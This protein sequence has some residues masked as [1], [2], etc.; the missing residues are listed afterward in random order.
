MIKSSKKFKVFLGTLFLAVLALF[1]VAYAA[2]DDGKITLTKTAKRYDDYGRKSHVAL[3]VSANSYTKS[4]KLDVVLVLD[5]SGSMA[6]GP[7]GEKDKVNVNNP[8]RLTSAKKAAKTFISTLITDDDSVK[9]G[10]VEYGESIK[11]TQALTENEKI[12]NNFIDNKYSARGGTNLQAG[13]EKAH[14]LLDNGSREDSKK[15]VVILTDGIPTFFNYEGK[16]YGH[17]DTDDSVCLRRGFFGCDL[18]KKPSEAAKEELD[19]LKNNYK[20]SDVYTI[21]LGNEKEAANILSKVNPEQENPLYKNYKALTGDELQ[22]RFNEILNNEI[23]TIGSSSVVTDTIPAKFKLTKESESNL[24][25]KGVEIVENEDGTTTL[26]WNIGTIETGKNYSLSYDVEALD[27]YHGSMY[28]N[29]S[30]I[31]KTTVKE[32]NPYYAGKTNQELEFNKPTTQVP[33]ITHDDN[34]SGYED[35]VVKGSIFDNDL[36]KIKELDK[37]KQTDKLEVRDTLIVKEDANTVKNN[38]GTYTLYKDGVAQGTLTIDENGKFT[39]TP[40]EGIVGDVSF[41]YSITTDVITNGKKDSVYSNES[42]VVINI[43]PIE[44]VE[45]EGS[46][47]WVDNNNQ[48]GIR[49][50]KI[51]VKLLANGNLVDSK[52]VNSKDNWTYKFTNLPKY[53]KYHENEE[54]YLIKYTIDEIEV[55]GYT[56]KVE[57]YNIV[58][59]HEVDKTKV[60]GTKTWVDNNNQDGIRPDKIRVNLLKNNKVIDTKEVTAND[61]WSYEFSNLDKNENGSEIKYSV[62]EDTITGYKTKIEGYNITNTHSPELYGSDGKYTVTKIW[63]DNNNQDGIRDSYEV[64]LTGVIEDQD[65]PVYENTV[66]LTKDKTSYTWTNLAKYNNGKEIKYTVD[67]TKVP[68]GYTK[69]VDG[70]KITNTHTPELINNNTGELKVTKIW[71]DNNNQDGIRPDKIKVSLYIDGKK[72]DKSLILSLDNNW[73]GK[74]TNLP[75]YKSE[76]KEVK[77]TVKEESIKNYTS[78][79]TG[80][81]ENGYVITNT[82][83][84]EL[85]GSDGKYTVTKIWNDNNNQDGIR[86]SYEV[87]LTG[88]I[89][90]QDEPVYE[91]T[92]TLTK[93]KTNYT[94][95]NL[96]KYN[97]GKEI[98]YTVDETKVPTGYTKIVDGTKITNIHTPELINN[99]TGELKVTKIW[100]DNNNQDGIRPDKIKVSLYIDGKKS[101]K[102][103]IL[104]LDNNWTG[105]FTNLPKY[106]SEGKEVKYTVKEESIK[107]YTSN[108][109]GSVENGYVITNTHSPELYGS[110]G[111]YTVTKI[112]NDNN[113]QDGIRDSYEVTLTGVIE[114]QDE[115][116]Y[117]NTVTLTKDKTSY[118]WSNL[119][120]YNNGKE[121]KYTVD[122]TKVPTGYTKLV[123]GTKITNTHET[124][125]TEVVGTKTWVDNNNQDGV[126]PKEIIVKLLANGVDTGKTVKVT[127][128]SNWQYS[129]TN[130]DTNSDGKEIKYTVEEQ[131]VPNYTTKV[132]GYNIINTHEVEKTEVAGTKTWLDNDNQDGKR[133]DKITIR[134]LANNVDTG[135]KA[136][137]SAD[138]DW[139]YSFTNL[140]KKANGKDIVYTVTED[141]VESYQGVIDGYNI[142]NTHTP[143]TITFSFEKIWV[144]AN[145]Q[146][147][148]RPDKIKVNLLAD[149]KV[150]DT[151]EITGE[152]KQN[153]QSNFTD[154]PKYNNGREI[155]YSVKEEAVPS[156][157]E[158]SYK[159]NNTII[160]THSPSKRMIEGTKTWN[161]NDNNDGIR[162]DKITVKLF[163]N[164]IDT[165]KT[166]EVSSK[167]NWQYKFEDLPEY[168]DGNKIIYTVNEEDVLGYSSE[169]KGFDI[170]NTH[171]VEKIS[172]SGTKIWDDHNNNDGIRPDEITVKLLANGIDTGKKVEVSS[173]T[174]W[175]YSFTDLNKYKNG[176]EITYSLEEVSVDG[177]ISEVNQED[178][179]ITNTHSPETITYTVNKKWV[180]ANNN[181]GIRPESINVSILANG[182]V[183]DKTSLSK[184]NNWTYTFGPYNKYENGNLIQ[185]TIV[186]DA[187]ECYVQTIEEGVIDNNNN[188]TSV[189]T[190]THEVEKE[191]ITI[192]KIWNDNN[193]EQQTRP[194]FINVKLLANG[195]VIREFTITKDMNWSYIL[196]NLNKYYNG[197]LINYSILEDKVDNYQ[198]SYN[199]FDIINTLT[200]KYEKAE[201]I[202]PQT[203]DNSSDSESIL[204]MILGLLSLTLALKRVN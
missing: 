67:E 53:T 141:E 16:V 201:I 144:D 193:N 175:Q 145:N 185:Y 89:E 157:Y 72:S 5:G 150:V 98:K 119:A 162:P 128:D 202:P 90:D 55:A 48:D 71:N 176:E 189:I 37:E 155:E 172:I 28:T 130:L 56:S 14:E 64:T 134:L 7:N 156:G 27:D 121:I 63:N 196:D 39:F 182:V 95:T 50:D 24:A 137:A 170:V 34:Y 154:L 60:S 15:L 73:T 86:D 19:S 43:K 61:N 57:G 23:K 181:D 152:T 135:L 3:N 2:D 114:N 163:A 178:Y 45:V 74:F 12:L 194:E 165:G 29:T 25:K 77:Y 51:T 52:T 113:N 68:T 82:H 147:G 26:K 41:K 81:V 79:N 83:T 76:G 192:N 129:F 167:T 138:T 174:N 123:D 116:V 143:E 47:I 87:T 22:E 171:E 122:E 44:R 101:D 102:S 131:K 200:K 58:N 199:G 21:T 164:N 94:W 111:K 190:N 179:N 35:E 62:V 177:Y 11:N 127:A 125:K 31:L 115:P 42:T 140:D 173:K 20:K 195:E 40:N 93:D 191:T 85:Y 105:K 103:L 80:S 100:N 133:P 180:D 9:I 36:N 49:P 88:V 109:T 46:K 106:K 118:T 158:V 204:F 92:V 65:E 38:D 18:Q 197:K 126:R 99:N 159:D 132:D 75:K 149:G 166:V 184:E 54:Q 183:I 186:E 33:I 168:R 32:D 59:T 6:Y 151:K 203:G 110:D 153:W 112:W 69:L 120:K 136:T 17:G 70:T 146:D 160:N 117:E 8:S 96:A 142:T 148:I 124:L 13:I 30:A 139:K 78:N 10:L 161:D 84:P 198:T 97:N 1:T 188:I 91:N 104:S 4:L 66:T 169:I 108:N 107:N 187:V